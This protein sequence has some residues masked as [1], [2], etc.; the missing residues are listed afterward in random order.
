[1]V[2]LKVNGVDHSFDGDPE[3]PLLW[4]LRDILGMAVPSMAAAWPSAAPVR[5]WKT[6]PRFDPAPKP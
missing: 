4:Y 5:C 6:E 1:M 2:Q 3:M